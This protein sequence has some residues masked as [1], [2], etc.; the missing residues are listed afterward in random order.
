MTSY[1]N[2]RIM[3]TTQQISRHELQFTYWHRWCS[4]GHRWHYITLHETFQMITLLL[5]CKL[6]I[7]HIPLPLQAFF[8]LT[9][10]HTMFLRIHLLLSNIIIYLDKVFITMFKRI[11]GVAL[12]EMEIVSWWLFGL[13]QS[14]FLFLFWEK[15]FDVVKFNFFMG[16]YGLFLYIY[17]RSV[18]IIL[19]TFIISLDFQCWIIIYICQSRV[20]NLIRFD[21][22][23]KFIVLKFRWRYRWNILSFYIFTLKNSINI[24]RWTD[25]FF[26]L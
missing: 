12:Y 6:F 5:P 16:T 20:T 7:Y 10:F 8:N 23:D 3:C 22:D 1:F 9:K 13:T 25:W 24:Y 14:V 26:V 15:L 17:R 19:R 4:I 18:R 21:L 11:A 2:F